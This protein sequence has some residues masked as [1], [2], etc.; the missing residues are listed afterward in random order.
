MVAS[1]CSFLMTVMVSYFVSDP[2]EVVPAHS[3]C[4]CSSLAG[5]EKQLPLL[6]FAISLYV[7]FVTLVDLFSLL[8]MQPLRSALIHHLGIPYI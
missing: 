5:M 8:S 2:H 3:C 4:V 7:F 1:Y 6:F